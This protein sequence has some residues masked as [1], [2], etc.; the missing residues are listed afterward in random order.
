MR[1]FGRAPFRVSLRPMQANADPA[2]VRLAALPVVASY[3]VLAALGLVWM[4]LAGAEG[5]PSLLPASSQLGAGLLGGAALA[6]GVIAATPALLRF[7]PQMQS[8]AT[9]IR[10]LIDGSSNRAL[11]AMALS[12]GIGEE[13][14]FRGGMQTSLGLVATTLVFGL[15]HG[16]PGTR[17]AAWGIFA[18][19]VGLGLGLIRELEQGLWGACLA[20]VTINYVNLRRILRYEPEGGQQSQD[21]SLQGALR[22][23]GEPDTAKAAEPDEVGQ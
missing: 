2:R 21:R 7:S 6:A 23:D 5:R 9:D 18:L 3:G 12:S 4:V 13:V 14:F 15:L 10:G 16:L 20:H 17:Y 8:L 19:V 11:L 1:A 22:D